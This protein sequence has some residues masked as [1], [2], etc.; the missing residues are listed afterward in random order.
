MPISKT[1]DVFKL[2]KSLTGAEKRSFRS[3]A[4]RNNEED[5]MYLKLFDLLDKQ[6][7]LN[8][9]QILN[10]LKF[11]HSGQYA[12]AKRHLYEQ[13]MI[14]LR[15]LNKR[16][17][18]IIQI[19]EYVDFAYVLYGKGL[20]MQALKILDKAKKLSK[21]DSSDL[22]TMVIVEAEKMIH[23]RYITRT[24]PNMIV[25]LVKESDVGFDKVKNGVALSSLWLT[26]HRYYINHGHIK[27]EQEAEEL[28]NY[29]KETM[30]NIDADSLGMMEQ[31]HLYQ[32][33]VWYYYILH[34]FEN[35]KEYARKWVDL[36]R[37]DSQK[38]ARDANLYLRGYHYLLTSL[39]YLNEYKEFE[40]A[41][42][43]LEEFRGSGYSSFNFNSKILSFLYVHTGRLNGH[44]M[45][46]S[47]GEGVKDI[48]K[49]LRRLSKYENYLDEHKVMI[50]YYKIAW[51]YL[52][53]QQPEKSITYL[54]EIINMTD[55]SLRLDI[56]AYARLMF[57]MAH[58]DLENEEIIPSFI[59]KFEYFKKKSN[60]TSTSQA[61]LL[62]FFKD[63][64]K[65]PLGSRKEIMRSHLAKLEELAENPYEKRNFLYLDTISW[66]RSKLSSDTLETTIKNNSRSHLIN[67]L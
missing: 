61:Q 31:V 32:S 16:K 46:P 38:Q 6:K 30:P 21:K 54:Q 10:K 35:C 39:Y 9:E 1:E 58:F 56:Q 63:Y 59:R 19:R 3:F 23:S 13:I 18:N 55:K 24:G 62:Q 67:K 53:N 17:K 57:L 5:L 41:L 7:S 34:D 12:N 43:E 66:L 49:T 40:L 11:I 36:F 52:G 44:I 25:D 26:L 8:E 64:I 50:F 22:S 33:Y 42:A 48:T 28:N 14:S 60:I 51:I 37:N 29:F 47:F 2:V 15:L 65:A 45:R 20:Y 4:K 27:T